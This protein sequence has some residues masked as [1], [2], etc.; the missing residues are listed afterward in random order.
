MS[1]TRVKVFTKLLFLSIFTLTWI[2]INTYFEQI[3]AGI[4]GAISGVIAFILSPSV[5]EIESQSGD[6]IQVKW[7]F[8]KS[9]II[10]K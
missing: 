5:K 2:V 4:A 3:N 9:L 10:S 6:H 1:K 8:L 7:I